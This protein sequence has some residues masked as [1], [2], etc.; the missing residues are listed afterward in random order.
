MEE[1]EVEVDGFGWGGF[2][3]GVFDRAVEV[4]GF[5]CRLCD[6]P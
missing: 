4:V 6:P 5:D 3:G 1:V 2:G